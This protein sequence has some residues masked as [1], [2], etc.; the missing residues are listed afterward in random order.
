MRK[1]KNDV[2]DFGVV[3]MFQKRKTFWQMLGFAKPDF[4]FDNSA[5]WQQFENG[6]KLEM[7]NAFHAYI[8]KA[9][10][11]DDLLVFM[12]TKGRQFLENKYND[13]KNEL[14]KGESPFYS[15][16]VPKETTLPQK[17]REI[18]EYT[19][20]QVKKDLNI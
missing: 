2:Y 13:Y 12:Y 4:D 5:F 10:N 19:F 16:Y 8:Y 17:A 15:S 6:L 14:A 7:R 9:K 1:I 3:K 11:I 18:L 20:N